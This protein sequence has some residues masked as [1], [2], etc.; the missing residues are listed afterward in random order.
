MVTRKRAREMTIGKS[1]HHSVDPD[2]IRM[3]KYSDFPRVFYQ[4]LRTRVSCS[5]RALPVN[6]THPLFN[7]NQS[8][9]SLSFDVH[10]YGAQ[11]PHDTYNT[12]R[13]SR[14]TRAV[15]GPQVRRCASSSFCCRRSFYVHGVFECL[16]HPMH[17]SHAHS[18][19]RELP[20]PPILWIRQSLRSK[21][22]LLIHFGLTS[23]N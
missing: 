8:L 13:I 6:A 10:L 22:L 16:L 11:V 17:R 14:V 12:S 5:L 20:I 3:L 2:V 9:F 21:W 19:R 18:I 1:S 7:R 23:S 4:L 15:C